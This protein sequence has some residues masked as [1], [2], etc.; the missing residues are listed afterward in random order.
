MNRLREKVLEVIKNNLI[1]FDDGEFLV[2]G[3]YY[4]PKYGCGTLDH[5]LDDI[6][7]LMVA[8]YEKLELHHKE[9]K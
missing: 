1:Q 4:V 6:E 5:L 3:K 2:E 9:I 7:E 8:E